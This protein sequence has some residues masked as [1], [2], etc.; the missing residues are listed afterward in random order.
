MLDFWP[1]ILAA[2]LSIS[3]P[4]GSMYFSTTEYEDV[5]LVIVNEDDNAYISY[6]SDTNDSQLSTISLTTPDNATMS[7]TL[8]VRGY[9]LEVITDDEIIIFANYTDTTVGISVMSREGILV[10]YITYDLDL[11]M[12]SYLV[13]ISSDVA[14]AKQLSRI[15]DPTEA[16]KVAFAKLAIDQT[17]NVFDFVKK[18]GEI[19]EKSGKF[20]KKD[21]LKYIT[22]KLIVDYLKSKVKAGSITYEVID[23]VNDMLAQTAGCLTGDPLGCPTLVYKSLKHTTELYSIYQDI[24]VT[25]EVT[26]KFIKETEALLAIKKREREERERLAQEE[27]EK[28]E[29][30]RDKD[31]WIECDDYSLKKVDGNCVAK[32]C[33]ADM[34]HCPSCNTLEEL[35]YNSDGSGYCELKPCAEDEKRDDAGL[36]CIAKTCA[37]DQYNCPTC[38][39]DETMIFYDDGSAECITTPECTEDEKLVN[40]VC[41]LLTCEADNVGCTVCEEEA[42]LVVTDG[43]D[44]GYCEKPTIEAGETS[45]YSISVTPNPVAQF[46]CPCDV[47]ANL[48]C[49][50]I[51]IAYYFAEGTDILLRIDYYEMIEYKGYWYSS[52]AQEV[53]YYDNG[54]IAE[55]ELREPTPQVPVVVEDHYW[56]ETGGRKSSYIFEVCEFVQKSQT[57]YEEFYESGRIKSRKLYIPYVGNDGRCRSFNNVMEWFYDQEDNQY[58]LKVTLSSIVNEFGILIQS[59]SIRKSWYEDGSIKI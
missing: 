23:N 27:L 49:N 41:T 5:P 38:T 33:Q 2:I 15:Y 56:Y 6:F 22:E 30:E 51:F 34:Y 8:D 29:L 12:Q 32:T 20:T 28:H 19:L 25:K 42:I 46:S 52:I 1:A 45:P 50:D 39:V 59:T 26:D 47:T 31:W 35:K 57:L 13:K 43:N 7:I 16:D 4:I 53:Y 21:A 54:N 14:L 36:F 37:T 40:G 24:K 3:S 18:A 48:C 10:E 9:P 44:T 11:V 58:S 55:I 17:I